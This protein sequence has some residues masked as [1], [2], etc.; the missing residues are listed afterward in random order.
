MT[1]QSYNLMCDVP[2][3]ISFN[4]IYQWRKNGAVLNESGAI[5]SFSQLRLSDA[6]QYTCEIVG[7]V[8]IVSRALNISLRSKSSIKI[9]TH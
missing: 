8:T 5:L 2:A 4:Y 1:G 6:G 7:N 9:N 3:S